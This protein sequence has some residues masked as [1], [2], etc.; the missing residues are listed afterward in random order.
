[1]QLY[2]H[3]KRQ[4]SEL[5]K[6][7]TKNKRVLLQAPTGCGKSVMSASMI[8]GSQ[9]KGKRSLFCV[10]RRELMKQMSN[11]F[12]KFDI[13]HSFVSSGKVFNPYAKTHIA[14]LG[15]LVRRLES[16]KPD[17]VFVDETHY[18][19]SQVEKVIAHYTEKGAYSIGLTATPIH[20][21]GKGLGRF[22][23]DMVLGVST[24]Y[25]IEHGFLSDYRAFAATKP[26]GLDK[27]SVRGGE[28]AQGELA[29]LMES[30]GYV[31]GNAVNEYCK[32]ARGMATVVFCVSR[33]HAQRVQ[34][35]FLQRGI[36]AGYIDGTHTDSQR[37]EIIRRFAS[38]QDEV[39]ISVNLL[40]YGF[41]LASASGMD[42]TIEAMIDLQPT[43]S[44]AMQLQ[45][46]GRVLRRKSTP[47]VILDNAGNLAEHGYPDD[48]REWTL[49]DRKK[50]AK[51]AA[52]ERE[53]AQTVVCKGCK[54]QYKIELPACPHCGKEREAVRDVEELDGELKELD[55]EAIKRQRAREQRQAQTLEQLI[56]LGKQRG[57]K[58]PEKWAA[59]VFTA[60]AKKGRV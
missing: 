46:W 45:K 9:A 7:L 22:Y 20:G 6:S 19:I 58:H 4:I 53:A 52:E 44:L 23:D 30:D 38:R 14:T 3:Q 29:E 15:T 34:E 54:S 31:I 13:D 26:S 21:S 16:V 41:D 33:K 2:D 25:L 51:S 27:I 42:I 40:Q 43:K 18:S 49:A 37:G 35:S 48:A 28:Y 50:R 55:R 57:M 39:L 59:Y 10:P 60:R 56:E 5:R 36:S 1:M 8:A 24:A 32:H 47:A 12:T 11:T 17:V